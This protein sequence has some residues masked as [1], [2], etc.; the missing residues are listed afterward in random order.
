MESKKSMIIAVVEAIHA[1]ALILTVKVFA[2]VC[3]GMVE[4]A[5]GK[6]IPMRCHYTSQALV[7]LGIILLV[8]A[9]VYEVRKE[10]VTSG[11]IAAIASILAILS[12][13]STLGMGVCMN[14]E[15]ACN[16]TAPIVK[17]VGAIGVLIG[18]VSIYLGIKSSK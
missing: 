15:M 8:N 10:A 7:F 9:L 16:L 4:T 5:A 14:P 12:L 18:I 6:Q 11:V 1:I 17:V 13:S 2:P 3:T